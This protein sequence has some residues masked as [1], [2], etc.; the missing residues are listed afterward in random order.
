MFNRLRSCVS[1]CIAASLSALVGFDFFTSQ[2]ATLSE[3]DSSVTLTGES[4]DLGK[5]QVRVQLCAVR[6]TK[7]PSKVRRWGIGLPV[8]TAISFLHVSVG[9]RKI[10]VPKQAYSNL[11]NICPRCITARE[12]NH[13]L[14]LSI[15][16]G[17]GDNHY[18]SRLQVADGFIKSRATV[19]GSYQYGYP[20]FERVDFAKNGVTSYSLTS[21]VPNALARTT[22]V[23]IP[24]RFQ[25]PRD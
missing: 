12:N 6:Q 3:S 22:G 23:R 17:D 16:G 20:P 10:I 11:R 19:G 2:A 9:G 13:Q 21:T 24:F 25:K 18:E 4:A 7:E 5:I 14:Y 15:I 1:L 8:D